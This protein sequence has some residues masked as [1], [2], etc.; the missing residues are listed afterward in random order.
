MARS[1]PELKGGS[2]VPPLGAP[3]PV[4][5]H[6]NERCRKVQCVAERKFGECESLVSL[7]H[8]HELGQLL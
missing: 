7:L 5:R 8:P 1:E 6:I 3:S 2:S 4:D